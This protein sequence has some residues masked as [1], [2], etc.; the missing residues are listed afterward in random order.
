M[1]I[2]DL[3]QGDILTYKNGHINIVNVNKEFKYKKYY[4]GNLKNKTNSDYDIV[5]V[6]RYKKSIFG[7]YRLKTIY[8]S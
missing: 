8:R 2:D 6:Q 4:H 5:K 7:L 1:I 3:K